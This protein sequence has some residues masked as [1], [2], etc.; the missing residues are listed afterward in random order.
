M[1]Y[2][3]KKRLKELENKKAISTLDPNRKKFYFNSIYDVFKKVGGYFGMEQEDF[4]K[5]TKKR[6]ILFP[7]QLCQYQISE[8]NKKIFNNKKY[9]TFT[10]GLFNESHSNIIHSYS[11]IEKFKKSPTTEGIKIREVLDLFPVNSLKNFEQ[12][13]LV[14]KLSSEK[15]RQFF[16]TVNNVCGKISLYFN[17]A[18]KGIKPYF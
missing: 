12:S 4:F 5:K 10:A 18:L 9:W 13:K 17:I 6:K 11:E 2:I 1:V 15:K 8:E 7:R 14:E 3:L 16:E